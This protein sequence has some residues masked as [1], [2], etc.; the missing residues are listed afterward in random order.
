MGV[1]G[2]GD[3]DEVAPGVRNI[4]HRRCVSDFN[5]GD[6]PGRKAVQ[7][8]DDGADGV[9]VRD[10]EDASARFDK[11]EDFAFK[12]VRHAPEGVAQALGGREE[13]PRD[14]PVCRLE[15]GMARVVVGKRR[16]RRVRRVAPRLH[17][18]GTVPRNGVFLQGAFKAAVVAFVQP[19]CAC[20]GDVG[21]A[22]FA[23]DDRRRIPRAGEGRSKAGVEGDTGGAEAASGGVRLPDAFR[24]ERASVSASVPTGTRLATNVRTL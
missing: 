21:K 18:T 16:G 19:P 2:N 13:F 15:T 3:V 20:N 23:E 22:Q 12:E 9:A 6:F 14:I 5:Y 24:G 11:R 8:R 17:L 7:A 10:D 1:S 4:G